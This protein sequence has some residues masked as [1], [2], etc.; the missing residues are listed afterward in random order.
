LQI[1]LPP[2]S[3]QLSHFLW[4][5]TLNCLVVFFRRLILNILDVILQAF[6]WQIVS[7]CRVT[8]SCCISR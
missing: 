1:F 4:R 7:I 6:L 2:P 8:S 5:L 3:A